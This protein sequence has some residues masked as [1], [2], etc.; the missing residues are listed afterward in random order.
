MEHVVKFLEYNLIVLLIACPIVVLYFIRKFCSK[1]VFRT[2]L[3]ASVFLTS[4]LMICFF[5]WNNLSRILLM[6]DYGVNRFATN[7]FER[8]LH[9]S[10]ENLYRVKQLENS[11]YGVAWQL[12]AFLVY[13]FYVP[14][15]FVVYFIAWILKPNN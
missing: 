10:K 14:Y 6:I 8:Y 3:I 2:Y 4:I 9:V 1:N 7:D 11:Y 5:W 13:V 15:I 12:R